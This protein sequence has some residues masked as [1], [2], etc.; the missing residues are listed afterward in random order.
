MPLNANQAEKPAKQK[1]VLKLEKQKEV[2]KKPLEGYD[3]ED[4]IFAL[5]IGTRT[6]VGIVGV[7]EKEIFKVIAAE[8]V[9]H[10]NRAMLDGQ[11]HDIKQ[12]AEVAKEVKESL[13]KII[14]TT[15][16]RVA[17]A[18]AGRVLKTC[19]VKIEREIEQ[20]R[21]ITQEMIG[22]IEM[23]AIQKAQLILDEEIAKDE[24]TQF[25][26][27]GYSI[28]NYYLNGYVISSLLGHRGKKIGVDILATF[29]PHI[30]VDSLYTVMAKIDLEVISLTLE[31]IAAINVT[32]PKD[33][34]LLNLALV[35]IGAGTSDI[36]I[37]KDGAVVAYAMAPIAG[38]E[39]T[40]KIAHH[41]LVDFNTGE[42][43]KICL[44]AKSENI[45]FVDI[46]GK[47][48]T[49][50]R[51]EVLE[52]IK[53][54]VEL[55]AETISQ[56]ILEYN[57]KAPNAVFLIGGGSQIPGLTE[58]VAE[59]L[60]L[61]KDR[62]VVRGRDIIQNVKF[63][64]KKLA[65]PEAITPFGIAITA[66]MQRGQDFLAVT[67]NGK[68]VRLF[69]SKKLTVA[70][71]LIL[72][73]YNANQ[74]IGRTGKGI[75]F[76]LNGIKKMLRGEHGKAAEIIVNGKT[77]SLDTM[78][79]PGDSITIIPAE[80]GKNAQA[81]VGNF[82]SQLRR[83]KV[84]LNGSVIDISTTVYINGKIAT[85]DSDISDGDVV[86]VHE[87]ATAAELFK[88]CEIDANEFNII[89]NGQAVNCGYILKNEDVI[90]CKW[91]EKGKEPVQVVD[92][93]EAEEH[94]IVI[95]E[96]KVL[97]SDVEAVE[98]NQNTSPLV[99]NDFASFNVTVNGKAVAMS[100]EK[101]QYIF[102]DI[103]NYIDFDLSK[104]QGNI[105]L[106][107]NGKPAAFTDAIKPGD[108]IDIFW[109]K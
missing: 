65:G 39:L 109:D 55:L 80:D 57:H 105:V 95:D 79:E 78:L 35:D 21:E 62:V 96:I 72:V 94:E 46:L 84:S 44:S 101:L 1:K 25:Y 12:V 11:I 47:K 29:L 89:I 9:E 20:G 66:Q 43:I 54:S 33:L 2:E 13:E 6:V 23:E 50:K 82:V 103:F 99:M 100:S 18:A 7:Q 75:S 73:G 38:D 71:S 106:K 69:N 60:K 45:T 81:K 52:V 28:I 42:K 87:I 104:P 41:Y 34:R 83:G 40:E 5:D 70:D 63:K 27:V 16:S 37:T 97:N 3:P 68:K 92:I 53:P 86:E 107:L 30:V 91:K 24:K 98:L 32:I 51:S 64:G 31:P 93:P 85:L 102:V 90:E 22:S 59:Q 76:E 14:G 77:A 56:K 67:V 49:I 36:A 15:L 19:E 10:K 58:M 4:L 74:L 17:I 8:V 88:V 61:P 26:C 108:V 48:N